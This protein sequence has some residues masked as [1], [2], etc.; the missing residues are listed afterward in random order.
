MNK[1]LLGKDATINSPTPKILPPVSKEEKLVY[2][3]QQRKKNEYKKYIIYS[4]EYRTQE[5]IARRIE[6]GHVRAI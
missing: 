1:L 4:Y 3:L 6:R 2:V 5:V